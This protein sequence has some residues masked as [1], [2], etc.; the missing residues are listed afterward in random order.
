M[1]EEYSP[2]GAF[3]GVLLTTKYGLFCL[4]WFFTMWLYWVSIIGI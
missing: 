4:S 2:L 3:F 1:G